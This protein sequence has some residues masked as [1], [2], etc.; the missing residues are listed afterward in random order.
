M[1]RVPIRFEETKLS[2]TVVE[3]KARDR[4][5]LLPLYYLMLA[6]IPLSLTVI[7]VTSVSACLYYSI[8]CLADI[9]CTTKILYY[10]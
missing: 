1:F 5:S 8:G 6:A 9:P 3:Y 4:S 2:N 10:V 7:V